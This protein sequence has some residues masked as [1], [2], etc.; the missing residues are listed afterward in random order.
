MGGGWW[1]VGGGL[2][3]VFTLVYIHDLYTIYSKQKQIPESVVI[4]I[5]R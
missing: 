2:L 5:T 3:Q 1:E 4:K